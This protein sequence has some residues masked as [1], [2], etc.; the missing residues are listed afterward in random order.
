MELQAFLKSKYEPAGSMKEATTLKTTDELL[1]NFND[2]LPFE[3]TKEDLFL[4]LEGAKFTYDEIDTRFVW[5]L[6]ER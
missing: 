1:T 5:M 6:K 2:H 3:I 4:V